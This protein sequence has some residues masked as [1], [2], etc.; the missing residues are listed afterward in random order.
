MQNINHCFKFIQEKGVKLV[1][2]GAEGT[3]ASSSLFSSFF[4]LSF[5]SHSF[6]SFLSFFFF[7]FC[8]CAEIVDNN[9][10]MILGMV[11]TLILRFEI[12]D[13][14]L[15]EMSAKDALLLWCQRKTQPYDNVDIQNF[16]MSWKDGL[17]FCALIH[18]HRPDLIDYAKLRRFLFVFFF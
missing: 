14:S 17:G 15:E 13:I 1:S 11:W 2:I 6:F 16:H 9:L 8:A 7:F 10:K 3:T 4:T 12:Q 5:F 18:R